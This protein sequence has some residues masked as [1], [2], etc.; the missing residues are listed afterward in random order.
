M[1]H[2]VLFTSSRLLGWGG[3][4]LRRFLRRSNTAETVHSKQFPEM[5]PLTRGVVQ[6][7]LSSGRIQCHTLALGQRQC[8]FL[9]PCQYEVAI[10][11]SKSRMNGAIQPVFQNPYTPNT[12][13]IKIR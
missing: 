13:L 10:S 8:A 3:N 1:T 6:F 2:R 5:L 12:P 11:F 7:L 4:R 9:N